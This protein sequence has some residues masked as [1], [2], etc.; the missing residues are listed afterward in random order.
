MSDPFSIAAEWLTR[1]QAAEYI[2][3]R[4]GIPITKDVLANRANI[5]DGPPYRIWSARPGVRCG[6]GVHAVYRPSDLDSWISTQLHEPA[7]ARNGAG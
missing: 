6:R 4:T 7:T 3:H 5:G 1:E 2:R